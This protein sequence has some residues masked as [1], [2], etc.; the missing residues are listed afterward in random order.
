MPDVNVFWGV[1]FNVHGLCV[2]V[3]QATRTEHVDAF[4]TVDR[5][6]GKPSSRWHRDAL[7]MGLARR[8]FDD[9]N[10]C[11]FRPTAVVLEQPAGQHRN[12]PLMAAWA[13]VGHALWGS[14]G[15]PLLDRTP[16]AWRSTVQLVPRTKDGAVRAVADRY[17][18][19]YD[20]DRA[21]ALLM[22]ECAWREARGHASDPGG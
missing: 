14:V 15:C 21:E 1:D 12:P 11:G 2:G 5:I 17:A 6:E 9:L 8:R 20:H 18:R 4:A 13:H 7:L 19:D 10:E 22:A 16:P 3:L